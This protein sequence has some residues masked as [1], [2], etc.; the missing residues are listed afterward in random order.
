M[1]KL[2]PPHNSVRVRNITASQE[3]AAN[4]LQQE[5]GKKKQKKKKKQGTKQRPE[6]HEQGKY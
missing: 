2:S 1:E 5:T 4:W 3:Y 6:S